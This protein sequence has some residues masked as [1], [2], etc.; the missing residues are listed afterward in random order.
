MTIY[1]FYS[2]E[3]KKLSDAKV[4]RE[5]AEAEAKAKTEQE[6]KERI[7]TLLPNILKDMFEW[8]M[9]ATENMPPEAYEFIKEIIN[10]EVEEGCDDSD[11]ELVIDQ[12]MIRCRTYDDEYS[13]FTE[14]PFSTS[15]YSD[16]SEFVKATESRLNLVFYPASPNFIRVEIWLDDSNYDDPENK[17]L[18]DVLQ[19]LYGNH[20]ECDYSYVYFDVDI[21]KIK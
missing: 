2:T 7:K 8:G 19:E 12:D 1:E 13:F 6:F 17:P 9:K 20:I 4:A 3:F 18:L 11:L 16:Y 10:I 14:E 15:D 21:D 5:K